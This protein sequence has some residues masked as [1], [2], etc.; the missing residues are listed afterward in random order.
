VWQLFQDQG[1]DGGAIPRCREINALKNGY[2]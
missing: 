2:P 1:K